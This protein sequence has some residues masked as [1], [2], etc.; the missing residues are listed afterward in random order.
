MVNRFGE[1]IWGETVADIGR[2]IL[3]IPTRKKRN[4][5]AAVVSYNIWRTRN[6]YLHKNEEPM[7]NTCAQMAIY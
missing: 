1:S 6:F 2:R 3:Q 4:I 5:Q 7:L